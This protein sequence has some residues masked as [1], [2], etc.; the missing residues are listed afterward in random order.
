VPRGASPDDV[1]HFHTAQWSHS[2][3]LRELVDL[4]LRVQVD[5]LGHEVQIRGMLLN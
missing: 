5:R 3:T 1:V 2:F 4:H